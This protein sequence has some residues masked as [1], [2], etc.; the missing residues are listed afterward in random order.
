MDELPFKTI[1][2]EEISA[3]NS[4]EDAAKIFSAVLKN[5]ATDAQ[6]NV[7]IVNSAFAL[8]CYSSKPLDEC[9]ALCTESIESKKAFLLFNR[10]MQS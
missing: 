10:I 4:I 8:K 9:I 7:V 1:K 5:E 6:K 2:P 3:G